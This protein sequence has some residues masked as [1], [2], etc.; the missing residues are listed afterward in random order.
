[1][2]HFGRICR[3][4]KPTIILS[5][6]LVNLYH[7]CDYT[8]Q[9]AKYNFFRNTSYQ[10]DTAQVYQQLQHILFTVFETIKSNSLRSL[11]WPRKEILEVFEL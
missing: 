11:I 4:K 3:R 8:E 2:Q 6:E 9:I 10:R 7:E 1:M 5:Q